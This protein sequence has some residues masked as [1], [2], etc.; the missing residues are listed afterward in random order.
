MKLTNVE[1]TV[2][3]TPDDGKRSCPKHVEF[4]DRINLDNWCVCLVIKKKKVTYYHKRTLQF[5]TTETFTYTLKIS[6]LTALKVERV[7]TS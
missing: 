2:K 3:K 6:I 4:Y 1:C 7:G 5:R